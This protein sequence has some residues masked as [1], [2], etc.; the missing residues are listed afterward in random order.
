MNSESEFDIVNN[1]LDNLLQILSSCYTEYT[2]IIN[3]IAYTFIIIELV[4]LGLLYSVN[5]VSFFEICFI[6]IIRI[7]LVL[8]LTIYMPNIHLIL[9]DSAL[10]LGS[11]T[12]SSQISIFLNPAKVFYLGMS[13]AE[14]ILKFHCEVV[15]FSPGKYVIQV[16][17]G[18]VAWLATVSCYLYIAI[19][20]FVNLLEFYFITILSMI[21]T[22]FLILTP[23]SW[24]G[25]NSIQVIILHAIKLY[26]TTFI[27]SIAYPWIEQINLS[28]NNLNNNKMWSIVG[29][30]I[31][32][33]AIIY[34]SS[35]WSNYYIQ[36]PN[37]ITMKN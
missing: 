23:I 13:I 27:I 2:P 6:S 1:L 22:P 4:R 33:A 5:E 10:Q 21:F 32:L 28:T 16:I 20:L 35:K 26:I 7:S 36:K 24:L 31:C 11:I 12:S 19:N 30:S 3:Y 8:S 34:R 15:K 18:V 37:F 25:F 9:R 17:Q 29:V 14:P